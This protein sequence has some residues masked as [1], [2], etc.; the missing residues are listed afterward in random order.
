MPLTSGIARLDGML[1]GFEMG[2]LVYL[3]GDLSASSLSHLLA[4]RAQLPAKRGGLGS[5]VIWL[6]GGNTF[7]PYGIAELS[8]GLGLD[9]ERVLKS[10]YLSRAFTC[11]QMSSLVLEKLWDAVERF[12]SKFVVISDLP[13]LY[14]QSDIPRKEAAKAFAP[15]VEELRTSPKRRNV[16]ILSTALEYSFTAQGSEIHETLVSSADVVLRLRERRGGVE[17]KLEKHPLGKT[18]KFVLGTGVLGVIPLDE[19]VGGVADG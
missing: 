17:V 8:R 2:E 1:G 4:V 18:G 7:N 13:F 19:F 15:V 6:D 14:I 12:R 3:K 11:Y 5:P 16:L 9:L 10:I